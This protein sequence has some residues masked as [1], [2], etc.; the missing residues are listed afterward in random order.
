MAFDQF[1]SSEGGMHAP[2]TIYHGLTVGVGYLLITNK[3]PLEKETKKKQH[4]SL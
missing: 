2:S 1:T 3:I 4:V